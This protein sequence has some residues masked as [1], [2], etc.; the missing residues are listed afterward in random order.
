MRKPT[1]QL[2]ILLMLVLVPLEIG[3]AYL[4]HET[5]GEVTSSLYFLAVAL[6]LVFIVAALRYPRAAGLGALALALAIVPYQLV[7]GD[8]LL[9]VQQ[10]A[11]RI[12][13]Y[14]YEERLAAGAYPADLSDYGYHD[15]AMQKYIQRYAADDSA[16]GF[17]LAYRVGTENTSHTYTPENGWGYYPD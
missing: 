5:I 10:E 8:R 2:F 15:P 17:F 13:A 3:C 6:N 4:V 1:T 7:L 16:G 12:V 11:S 9:R 14:A